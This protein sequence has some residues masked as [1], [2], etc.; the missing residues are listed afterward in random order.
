MTRN[1]QP[2]R[3]T[4]TYPSTG[5]FFRSFAEQPVDVYF[6]TEKLQKQLS[7]QRDLQR[8]WGDAGAKRITLR[9]Q[10]LEA[11]VTLEDMRQLPGRCHELFGD[12]DGELAVDVHQGH[13]LIFRPTDDPPPEK[14]DGGLD[15]S[16]VESVIVTEI[17]D[18]H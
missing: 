18:Y 13:R 14:V 15:W 9:L 4:S 10:Q 3:P 17:V 2:R 8:K 7:S 16:Q 12:R 1:I 11:A 6:T 5:A